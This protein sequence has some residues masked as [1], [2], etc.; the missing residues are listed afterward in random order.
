[1]RSARK[2]RIKIYFLV[3]FLY[4]YQNLPFIVFFEFEPR[5][6]KIRAYALALHEIYHPIY[7]SLK[8]YLSRYFNCLKVLR[9]GKY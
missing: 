8:F 3:N 5:E 2:G 9:V 4:K 6:A 1:M 7:N